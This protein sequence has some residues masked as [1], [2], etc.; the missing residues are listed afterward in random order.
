[1]TGV[2]SGYIMVFLLLFFVFV[3]HV[4]IIK[5]LYLLLFQKCVLQAFDP[6]DALEKAKGFCAQTGLEK[7]MTFTW[8]V[9]WKLEKSYCKDCY[10]TQ[11]IPNLFDHRIF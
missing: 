9:S 11:C 10:H 1:M 2:I 7:A 4:N 3:C 8:K 5:T 6:V